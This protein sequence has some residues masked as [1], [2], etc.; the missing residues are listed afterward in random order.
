MIKKV[1]LIISSEEGLA[2]TAVGTDFSIEEYAEIYYSLADNGTDITIAS[3]KGGQL[4]VAAFEFTT[5]LN[6]KPI[7]KRFKEDVETQLKFAHSL[8]L[9]NIKEIDFDG[10]FF[11]G[12]QGVLQDLL[13]DRDALNLIESFYRNNKPLAFVGHAA[14]IL[15]F[16][17]NTLGEPLVK[18]KKL[19]A[20]S[21]EEQALVTSPFKPNISVQD[22]LIES[23]AVYSKGENSKPMVIQDGL[24]VTGQNAQSAKMVAEKLIEL[25]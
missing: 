7:L 10:L 22:V 19:T 11:A 18:G 4:P 5:L 15:Q 13:I 12:G 9:V 17:K 8:Q 14:A 25:L 6:K 2:Q 21:N 1:L 23:G 3:P 16:A 20:F 24:L